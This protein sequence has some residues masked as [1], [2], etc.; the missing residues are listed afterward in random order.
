MPTEQEKQVE[1][2]RAQ[3]IAAE[4]GVIRLGL[5]ANGEI[6]VDVTVKTALSQMPELVRIFDGAASA[7]MSTFQELSGVGI[8]HME[9]IGHT[10]KMPN[11]EKTVDKI[12][13]PDQVA[14]QDDS[15]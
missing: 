9:T 3:A 14:G 15:K 1:A 2:A 13:W 11:F 10:D 5:S 6:T 7:F 12:N 8:N 4:L